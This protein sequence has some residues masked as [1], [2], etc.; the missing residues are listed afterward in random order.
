MTAIHQ[1]KHE[2]CKNRGGNS[3]F[4]YI[5]IH[6]HTKTYIY[7]YY[8]HIHTFTHI[9]IHF[10]YIH[11][12]LHTSSDIFKQTIQTDIYRRHSIVTVVGRSSQCLHVLHRTKKET[13]M[14]WSSLPRESGSNSFSTYHTTE[15]SVCSPSLSRV[16][17]F[18]LTKCSS[19]RANANV[20]SLMISNSAISHVIPKC[21]HT[22]HIFRQ[23]ADHSSAVWSS[24]KTDLL[25]H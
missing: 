3:S 17:L 25:C 16:E 4:S 18:S 22:D 10:T 8:I 6:I 7:I 12:H 21:T 20:Q 9:Y 1:F 15:T 19:H 14:S 2:E 5:Y 13:N 11:I 23:C 24:I